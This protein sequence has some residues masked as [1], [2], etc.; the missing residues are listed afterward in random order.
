MLEKINVREPTRWLCTKTTVK[1]DEL[2]M[3]ERGREPTLQVVYMPGAHNH[4]C[5]YTH[6][7]YTHTIIIQIILRITT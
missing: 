4:P 1:P 6:H 5:L 7:L 2:G 3:K